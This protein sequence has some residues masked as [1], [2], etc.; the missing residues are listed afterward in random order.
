MSWQV[1]HLFTDLETV[2]TFQVSQG[3]ATAA[4]PLWSERLTSDFPYQAAIGWTAK[5][6]GR[7]WLSYNYMLTALHPG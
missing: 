1:V 7:S 4:W 5:S 2:L 6:V 3:M